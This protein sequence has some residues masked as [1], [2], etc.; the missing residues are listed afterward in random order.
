MGDT[1]RHEEFLQVLKQCHQVMHAAVG[2]QPAWYL[3]AVGVKSSH[4]GQGLGS[5]LLGKMLARCDRLGRP[6]YL[7]S[8]S[9]RN[10]AF[11]QRLGYER[12]AD[13]LPSIIEVPG[14]SEPLVPMLRQPTAASV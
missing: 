14:G 13:P 9:Q 1:S 3:A 8:S 7:E 10:L 4:K 6:A 11:Y 5:R 2:D 12:L